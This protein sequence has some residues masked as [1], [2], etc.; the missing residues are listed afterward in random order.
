M[1]SVCGCMGLLYRDIKISQDSV[2]QPTILE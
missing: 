2:G 1:L